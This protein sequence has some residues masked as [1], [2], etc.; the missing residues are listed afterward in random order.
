MH[1]LEFYFS[2]DVVTLIPLV[3]VASMLAK[4]PAE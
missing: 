2:G 3:H 4:E 1:V